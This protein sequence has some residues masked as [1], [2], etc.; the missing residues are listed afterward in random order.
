MPIQATLGLNAPQQKA[1]INLAGWIL[2]HAYDG[3]NVSSHDIMPRH[4]SERVRMRPRLALKSY[5]QPDMKAAIAVWQVVC[6][7]CT[8]LLWCVMHSGCGIKIGCCCESV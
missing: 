8:G 7:L 1:L 5:L 6:T 4:A 3:C 2:P